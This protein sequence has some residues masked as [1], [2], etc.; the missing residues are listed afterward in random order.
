M[1]EGQTGTNQGTPSMVTSLCRN[2]ERG[3]MPSRLKAYITCESDVTERCCPACDPPWTNVNTNKTEMDLALPAGEHR[4]D[5]DHLPITTHFDGCRAGV[6]GFLLL[7]S[8]R[9]YSANM[10]YT[11]QRRSHCEASDLGE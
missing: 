4:S 1:V 7:L 3:I 5:Y 11:C 9:L 10:I 8:L 2:L 6:Q